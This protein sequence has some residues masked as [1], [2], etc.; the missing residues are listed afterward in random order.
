V[1]RGQCAEGTVLWGTRKKGSMK[2]IKGVV[3]KR[4]H[5]RIGGECEKGQRANGGRGGGDNQAC[6]QTVYNRKP[7][8]NRNKGEKFLTSTKTAKQP[9]SKVKRKPLKAGPKDGGITA[10]D[11]WKREKKRGRVLPR[12]ESNQP[13]V[14][15]RGTEKTQRDC[16][17]RI[18]RSRKR[19]LS[20]LDTNVDVK[21]QNLCPN[22][23]EP[24][25]K[26]KTTNKVQFWGQNPKKMTAKR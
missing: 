7:P 23:M 22:P 2:E 24:D 4:L 11:R 8:R 1:G 18:N 20:C 14:L 12:A 6:L 10:R 17:Q 13:L 3:V 21:D 26:R 19:I 16:A 5:Q 25:Q 9:A 15:T